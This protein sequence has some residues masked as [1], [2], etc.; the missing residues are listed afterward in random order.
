MENSAN[1]LLD[2]VIRAS[3]LDQNHSEDGEISTKVLVDYSMERR[4]KQKMLCSQLQVLRFLLEFLEKADTASW[5][6]TSPE[7]LKKELQVLQDLV[8]KKGKCLDLCQTRIHDLEEEIR[9]LEEFV[10]TWIQ[11]VLW[12][13]TFCSLLRTLQGVCL[14]S[15]GESELILDLVVDQMPETPTMRLNMCWTSQ[16]SLH[17]K[18]DESVPVPPQELLTDSE[19]Y[20]LYVILEVQC[21]Y[22]SQARVLR[23]LD[24]Q[25]TGT[26]QSEPW[27][28]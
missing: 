5:E 23:E 25:L 20:L 1:R 15:V 10:D 22:H 8:V 28:F 4:R 21:W 18:T 9:R 12:D 3:C 13:S 2:S 26:L 19:S 17:V 11:A 6:E 24:L 27:G 7:I 14:V 16:G